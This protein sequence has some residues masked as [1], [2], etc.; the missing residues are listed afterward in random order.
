MSA[1]VERVA[2]ID[3]ISAVF[4]TLRRDM[5]L[6]DACWPQLLGMPLLGFDS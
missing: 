4:P 3:G 1:S 6:D 2:W 5:G